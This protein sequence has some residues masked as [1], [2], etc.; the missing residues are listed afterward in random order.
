MWRIRATGPGGNSPWSDAGIFS[1]QLATPASVQ[2]RALSCTD[3]HLTWTDASTSEDG[4][5]IY[6]DSG[7]A[8]EIGANENE[9]V[10]G[11][12]S[13]GAEHT[14]RVRAFRGQFESA[15]GGPVSV[16][17]PPCDVT[18]PEGTFTAPEDGSTLRQPSVRLEASASDAGSGVDR[19][20]FLARWDGGDWQELATIT[21]PPYRLDWDVCAAG[22]PDGP[23]DLRLRTFDVAGND[24]TETID[25]A[26][27]VN[28]GPND[29]PAPPSI[30][31]PAGGAHL[32]GSSIGIAIAASD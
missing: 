6:R 22:V 30:E 7:L 4:Y 3:V 9:F 16:T 2:A 18:P 17:T 20:R 8:A 12:L 32:S 15:A 10:A 28:C 11:G 24:A 1:V 29:P 14:F 27:R 31:T 25:I 19:V 23:I 21:E 5:R 13:D 26:K